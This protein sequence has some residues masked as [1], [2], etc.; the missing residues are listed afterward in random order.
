MMDTFLGCSGRGKVMV[1]VMMRVMMIAADLNGAVS[2]LVVDGEQESVSSLEPNQQVL[3]TELDAGHNELVI[4]TA[5][6]PEP[7]L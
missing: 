4:I 5:R 6:I 1:M 2:G 7:N 3:P